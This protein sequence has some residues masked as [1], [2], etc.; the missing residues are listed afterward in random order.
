[1]SV[2]DFADSVPEIAAQ[3]KQDPILVAEMVG[4]GHAEEI[5]AA[6]REKAEQADFPVYVV[7][8]QTPTGLTEESVNEQLANLL[9]AKL[10]GDGVY[11]VDTT[12]GPGYIGVWGDLDPGAEDD[13]VDLSLAVG[14]GYQRVRSAVEDEY[15]DDRTPSDLTK[16]GLTLDL[17]AQGPLT[18]QDSFP[19]EVVPQ[20][21]TTTWTT[22]E[23]RMAPETELPGP[24]LQAA[25]AAAVGITVTA[26]AYRLLRAASAAVRHRRA[27]AAAAPQPEEVRKQAEGELKVLDR[28]LGDTGETDFAARDLARGSGEVARRLVDSEELLDVVGALVLARIGRH[29]LED[30]DGSPY[31]C[32]YVN[33]LHGAGKVHASLGGGVSVPVCRRCRA[34]LQADREPDALVEVRRMARDRPYYTGD[35]VWARTGFGAISDD[36]WRQVDRKDTA[37]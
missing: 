2:D 26:V 12:E 15:G 37:R 24:G 5:G 1:M 28:A 34:D 17:V 9:H 18:E 22:L 13:E 29:A 8:T 14:E 35:T 32:C 25:V 19:S 23:Y 21:T 31:R 10:G 16:A 20:Y 6:L 11:V 30:G 27:A 7:Y 33:P 3:L 36:L 4:N